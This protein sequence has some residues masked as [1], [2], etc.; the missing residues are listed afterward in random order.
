MDILE[1]VGL[2]WC[3]DVPCGHAAEGRV[4][5]KCGF[6]RAFA[7]LRQ[8][9]GHAFVH[10]HIVLLYAFALHDGVEVYPRDDRKSKN[11]D[12]I[13]PNLGLLGLLKGCGQGGFVRFVCILHS[14]DCLFNFFKISIFSYIW[15]DAGILRR[16]CFCICP[17]LSE[18]LQLFFELSHFSSKYPL[19]N[20]IENVENQN[21]D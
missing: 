6:A 4:G 13:M 16:F 21:S 19:D 18:L 1:E 10:L 11:G 2:L 17:F 3:W 14:L 12:D 7:V 15:I 9:L 20:Q 5:P 8:L